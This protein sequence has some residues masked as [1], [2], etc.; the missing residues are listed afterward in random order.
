MIWFGD[1]AAAVP[2]YHR[3]ADTPDV[4]EPDKLLAA[5]RIAGMTALTFAE[6]EPAIR[7]MLQARAEALL[8]GDEADFLQLA[9]DR[10]QPGQNHWFDDVAALNLAE[11]VMLPADLIMAG[12]IATTT[13]NT[14]ITYLQDDLTRK[15]LS[16]S[17][18]AHACIATPLAGAGMVRLWSRTRPRVERSPSPILRTKLSMLRVWRRRLESRYASVASL[19]G[20]PTD[21][22]ASIL[23]YP[24]R[25]SLQTDTAPVSAGATTWVGPDTIKLVASPTISQTQTFADA[26]TQLVLANTGMTEADAPWLWRALPAV[27]TTQS[28]P[29]RQGEYVPALATVLKTDA[30]PAQ[31]AADWA[32]VDYLQRQVGWEGIGQIVQQLGRGQSLDDALNEALGMNASAFEDAWLADWR[33]RIRQTTADLDALLL[34][35]QNAV[36]CGDEAA[37]LQSIDSD[38]PAILADEQ[39]W[40]R[41]VQAQGV[42]NYILEGR[43]LAYLD[44]GG[45]LAEI[46]SSYRPRQWRQHLQ[47]H[48]HHPPH[49]RFRWLPLGRSRSGYTHQREGCRLLSR[50]D[51]RRWPSRS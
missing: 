33:A 28:D 24:D 37:F 47:R 38:D 8:A 23:L 46:K 4:I 14:E 18:D 10:T 21:A 31:E 17:Q 13:V 3:P 22:R 6:G 1:D 5:G 19:L 32:K 50:P 16:L 29:Q 44:N 39:A 40:W 26:A 34:A 48:L 12:D 25:K 27:I 42:A 43:P 36:A 2:H 7:D 49:I 15:K 35:R 9:T 41:Q 30:L 20:L 51:E 45:L 11:V